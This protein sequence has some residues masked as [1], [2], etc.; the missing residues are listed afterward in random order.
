MDQRKWR[1]AS[2]KARHLGYQIPVTYLNWDMQAA[3]RYCN[4]PTTRISIC[5]YVGGTEMRHLSVISY[6]VMWAVDR[7]WL[8]GR[9]TDLSTK[10]RNPS[11][12][13]KATESKSQIPYPRSYLRF[14]W[15][16]WAVCGRKAL[17]ALEWSCQTFFGQSGRSKL[18]LV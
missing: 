7:L 17:W 6:M 11:L 3:K 15:G 8:C 2:S 10:L 18:F 9:Q 14:F 4:G 13:Y 5:G 16:L 1:Y 12:K